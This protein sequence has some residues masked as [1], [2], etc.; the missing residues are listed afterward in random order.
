MKIANFYFL[1]RLSLTFVILSGSLT[2][3]ADQEV[4][5]DSLLIDHPLINKYPL[6]SEVDIGIFDSP[7]SLKTY[8][9]AREELTSE[10]PNL[11]E[12]PPETSLISSDLTKHGSSFEDIYRYVNKDAINAVNVIFIK[13]L[14]ASLLKLIPLEY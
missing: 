7:D 4:P 1:S 8:L 9:S 11:S 3:T 5:K 12:I 6:S 13:F 10:N 14:I 2:Y